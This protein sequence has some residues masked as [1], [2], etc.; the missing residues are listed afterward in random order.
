[1]GHLDSHCHFDAPEFDTDRERVAA[2]T[3][4]AGVSE[5]VLPGVGVEW[6]ER[7]PVPAHGLRLHRAAGLHPCYDHP[8]DALER[9][10]RAL[11]SGAFVAIG[12]TGLDRRHPAPG[13]S[14]LCAAQLDLAR[15]YR[16][17]LILHVVHAHE[18]LFALLKARPG[19]TGVVHAFAGPW[20]L[21]RRYLDLGFK[22]GIGGIATWP[23]A[24]KLQG[25]VARCPAD[26]YVLETDAP[27]LSP[28]WRRGERN[29]PS[30]ILAIAGAVARLR[31]EDPI[32]VLACS[33]ASGRALFQ[34]QEK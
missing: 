28:E 18:E 4:G 30:E 32:E 23:T 22:L 12:E 14:T 3:L 15:A 31:G 34:L 1:M 19:L 17:P 27:D 16:L 24:R 6:F 33:D 7:S 26:G 29:E 8:P 11:D 13:A 5:L 2:R 20:E 10:E 9:L 21:A 25:A